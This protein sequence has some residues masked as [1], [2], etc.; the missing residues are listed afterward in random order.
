MS[1]LSSLTSDESGRDLEV[2]INYS[3]PKLM[4]CQRRDD[5]SNEDHCF[6]YSEEISFQSS[7]R[8][9]NDYFSSSNESY[10]KLE[11]PTISRS[12]LTSKK[13]EYNIILDVC[14]T[15]FLTP[16]CRI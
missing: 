12:I 13:A 6:N 5:Y 14:I 2:G 9:R 3:N 7:Y 11:K 16:I 1:F 4:N 15:L 10:L 8:S